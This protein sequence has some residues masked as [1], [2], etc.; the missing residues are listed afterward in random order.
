M[1]SN[2]LTSGLD[3]EMDKESSIALCSSPQLSDLDSRAISLHLTS[4][5]TAGR[6][7]AEN[8]IYSRQV[9]LKQMLLRVASCFRGFQVRVALPLIDRIRI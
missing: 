4:V 1:A 7:T 6:S 8:Q 5:S 2:S 9:T 3:N